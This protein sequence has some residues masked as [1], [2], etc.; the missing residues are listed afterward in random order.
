[1][2]SQRDQNASYRGLE[3]ILNSIAQWITKYRYAGGMSDQSGQW[4]GPDEVANIARDLGLSPN[5]LKTLASKGP[6]A[7]NLLQKM[8]VALD[9]DPKSLAFEDPLIM[10]DLQRRCVVCEHNRRQCEYDM[11]ANNYPDYCP[12][13]F[14]LDATS[15]IRIA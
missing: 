4:C 6:E 7:T 15:A 11:A 1:M 14:P 12:N 8:L 9:V 10:R 3:F 2:S 13:A 5:K